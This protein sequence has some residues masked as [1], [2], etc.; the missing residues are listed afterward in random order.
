MSADFFPISYGEIRRNTAQKQR[1]LVTTITN[2]LTCWRPHGDSNPG[3]RRE[4]AI[5]K[6][7]NQVLTKECRCFAEDAMKTLLAVALIVAAT[8][9]HAQSNPGEPVWPVVGP[10]ACKAGQVR[11][12]GRCLTPLPPI[13]KTGQVDFAKAMNDDQAWLDYWKDGQ[14]RVA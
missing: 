5:Q 8:Q 7:I 12:E 11:F 1:P 13:C 10:L 4:R 2:G 9:T 3:Y 6:S 14:I